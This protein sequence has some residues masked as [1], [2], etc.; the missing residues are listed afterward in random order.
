MTIR[1]SKNLF[2]IAGL[3]VIVYVDLDDIREHKRVGSC[4]YV[5]FMYVQVRLS[6]NREKGPVIFY[7]LYESL[8][9]MPA[10]I[11]LSDHS[12]CIH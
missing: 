2:Y 3:C 9:C 10:L 7:D 1:T 12:T 6:A 5:N 8:Q 11:C 4:E